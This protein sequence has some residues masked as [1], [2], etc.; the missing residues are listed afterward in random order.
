M[1]STHNT[2]FQVLTL[3]TEVK[4]THNIHSLRTGCIKI[5][6][7]TSILDFLRFCSLSGVVCHVKTNL[8]SNP[9]ICGS[10]AFPKYSNVFQSITSITG[11][12]TADSSSAILMFLEEEINTL[13]ENILLREASNNSFYYEILSKTRPVKKRKQWWTPNPRFLNSCC[14]IRKKWLQE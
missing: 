10:P 4:S 14:N 7:I 12:T 5:N 2:F 3:P 9:P 1:V 6:L 13:G 11:H 8:Q